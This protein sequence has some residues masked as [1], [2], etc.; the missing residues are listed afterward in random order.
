MGYKFPRGGKN[1][2]TKI[3]KGNR[4]LGTLLFPHHRYVVDSNEIHKYDIKLVS[5]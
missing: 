5:F 4:E 1:A 2:L 3:H